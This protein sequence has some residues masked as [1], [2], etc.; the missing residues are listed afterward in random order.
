MHPPLSGVMPC[1]TQRNWRCLGC[2]LAAEGEACTTQGT[3]RVVA[4]VTR[5][6]RAVCAP[7]LDCLV[8]N[9]FCFRALSFCEY[10]CEYCNQR[11]VLFYYL[12]RSYNY[13]WLYYNERILKFQEYKKPTMGPS[14][15][16]S[17]LYQPLKPTMGPSFVVLWF[18]F[19]L[20]NTSMVWCVWLLPR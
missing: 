19:Q 14:C 13:E 8:A 6:V 1:D 16:I 20:R 11:V 15:F 5:S 9:K 18:A 4:K 3:W 12:N 10:F 2:C 17:V 7:A